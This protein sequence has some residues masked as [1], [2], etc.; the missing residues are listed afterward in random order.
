MNRKIKIIL[1]ICLL[2]FIWTEDCCEAV[3]IATDNCGGL[4]CYIPQCTENCDWEPMQCW[5]S[6]GYCWCVDENGIEIEGTSTPS[7]QGLPDCEEPLEECFDFT[8]IDFGACTMVLGV[9]LIN[10]ECNYISGCDWSID[11]IDYSS[12]FFD[13]I[14][15]CGDICENDSLGNLGDINFDNETN[16]LDVVL[17]IS[18]IIGEPANE[19]EYM[20]ADINE[21]G[22]LNVLDAVLLIEMILNPQLANEC[23]VIPEVGPCDGICPTYYYNQ[24]T[25]EC[26]EFITGCCGIEG[27]NTLQEC[28]DT[29]E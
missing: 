16:V 11:G 15:E 3:D 17:L 25:N 2:N 24:S 20:A 7:W 29:C 5:S 26:E 8:E 10:S 9:G 18:F 21:D 19:Y 13:S 1:S 4:G 22:L 27:F 12:L 23:Y 6:T 28:Q 14:E